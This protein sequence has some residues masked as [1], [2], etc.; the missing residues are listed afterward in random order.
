M[1]KYSEFKNET[2]YLKTLATPMEYI[3][4]DDILWVIKYMIVNFGPFKRM[5]NTQTHL[6]IKFIKAY[7]QATRNEVNDKYNAAIEKLSKTE[8]DITT[9]VTQIIRIEDSDYGYMYEAQ[10]IYEIEPEVTQES[11]PEEIAELNEA[12]REFMRFQIGNLRAKHFDSDEQSGGAKK[13]SKMSMS[14]TPNKK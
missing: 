10:D 8:V 9:P 7:E 5:T 11:T 2:R 14:P 4:K 6:F 3:H 13:K 1:E 12:K